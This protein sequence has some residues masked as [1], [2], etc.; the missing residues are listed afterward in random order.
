MASYVAEAGD[1]AGNHATIGGRNR[2]TFLARHASYSF[3]GVVSAAYNS[4]NSPPDGNRG[5]RYETSSFGHQRSPSGFQ[6]QLLFRSDTE[7]QRPDRIYRRAAKRPEHAQC[8][9]QP[10]QFRPDSGAE[11]S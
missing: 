7:H 10:S 3:R 6:R 9:T 2:I 1:L 11:Y 8:S 4:A 5:V